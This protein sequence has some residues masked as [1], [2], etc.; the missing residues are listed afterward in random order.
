MYRLSSV[1]DQG[2]ESEL[3][4][5]DPRDAASRPIHCTPSWTLSVINR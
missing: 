3:T 5:T 4:Q 2:N 1:D